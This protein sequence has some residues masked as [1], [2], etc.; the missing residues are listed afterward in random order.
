MK[1]IHVLIADDHKLLREALVILLQQKDWVEVIS[2]AADGQ[3]ALKNTL[4]LKP[5]LVI[6]DISLPLLNGIEVASRIKAEAP[7]IKIIILTMHKSEEYIRGAFQTGVSAYLL[8]ENALED[9]ITAIE[10][11][12]AGK[13]YI[14]QQI[15]PVIVSGYLKSVQYDNTKDVISHREREILQLLAEGYYNKDIADLL[16]LS[17]KTVETHRANIMKKLGLRS[18]TDL[19]L[20]AV[21]NHIIEA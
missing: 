16:N 13:V 5:D 4:Q 7:E 19:V 6:L 8:K 3:E 10:A 9:L 20:Y 11:A 12:M 1:K 17:V 18:I 21:R 15:A 14:S 2:Q